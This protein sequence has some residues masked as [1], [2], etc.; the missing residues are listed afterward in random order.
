MPRALAKNSW[1]A[2]QAAVPLIKAEQVWQCMLKHS[3]LNDGGTRSIGCDW[4]RVLACVRVEPRKAKCQ[5]P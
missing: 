4:G 2:R 5:K 1:M 3:E